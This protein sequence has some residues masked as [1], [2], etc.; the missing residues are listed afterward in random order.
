[1]QIK[2][3]V[4]RNSFTFR[5]NSAAEIIMTCRIWT[6]PH[7]HPVGDD[8]LLGKRPHCVIHFP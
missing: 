6:S 8:R 7:S 4:Q 5:E 3:Q 2:I 1:L